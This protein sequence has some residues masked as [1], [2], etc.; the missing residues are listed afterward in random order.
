M[1]STIAQPE[2]HHRE[3]GTEIEAEGLDLGD[4]VIDYPMRTGIDAVVTFHVYP[5]EAEVVSVMFDDVEVKDRLTPSG[6]SR[7]QDRANDLIGTF[8]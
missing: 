4:G 7:L 8:R 6:E 1:S 2:I 5:D 3:Y